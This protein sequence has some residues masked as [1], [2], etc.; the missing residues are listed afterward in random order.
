M[1]AT[2]E[3]RT[4]DIKFPFSLTFTGMPQHGYYVHTAESTIQHIVRA[5]PDTNMATGNLIV[6]YVQY[7]AGMVGNAA[8]D[9]ITDKSQYRTSTLYSGDDITARGYMNKIWDYGQKINQQKPDY[10]Y[11][12]C[13]FVG[14]GHYSQCSQS[15]SNAFIQKSAEYAGLTM[16]IPL[17]NKGYPVWMPG[18]KSEIRDTL[19]DNVYGKVSKITADK[20][21]EI[22]SK[23]IS[24]RSEA[25]SNT[26]K[27]FKEAELMYGSNKKAEDIKKIAD[28]FHKWQNDK[29]EAMSKS[30]DDQRIALETQANA[31]C[32][33]KGLE[34]EASA[35]CGPSTPGAVKTHT[36]TTSGGSPGICM[37]GTFGGN[38]LGGC[39]PSTLWIHN[40]HY[41]RCDIKVPCDDIRAKYQAILDK[42]N[43][44]SDLQYQKDKDEQKLFI[45]KQINLLLQTL[46]KTQT[47]SDLAPTFN[48]MKVNLVGQLNAIKTELCDQYGLNHEV[49]A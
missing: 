6:D 30:Q 23:Y 33:A 48:E 38:H 3:L 4:R 25:M 32:K 2:I 36:D 11:A 14:I 21:E 26:Q 31:E 16:K 40:Y 42:G 28:Q 17:D 24:K 41:W 44:E 27:A 39:S 29:L 34:V 49:F 13:D 18:L 7:H 45:Q 19:F 46:D 22:Y 1:P 5:G 43:I 15:N 12:I 47:N 37:S 10:K 35:P 8:T 20:A 9:W